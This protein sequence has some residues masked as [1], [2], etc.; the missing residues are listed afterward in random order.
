MHKTLDGDLKG[1]SNIECCCFF[2]LNCVNVSDL[3]HRIVDIYMKMTHIRVLSNRCKRTTIL[4][5]HDDNLRTHL[6]RN[7]NFY[8]CV[9]V[10]MY[11]TPNCQ[12]RLFDRCNPL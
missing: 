6:H 5:V 9:T 10:Y 2:L 12:L 7:G 11:S 4:N 1:K 3:D 8:V